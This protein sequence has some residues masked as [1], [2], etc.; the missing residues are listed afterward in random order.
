MLQICFGIYPVLACSHFLRFWGRWWMPNKMIRA[1]IQN[2]KLNRLR[3]PSS[4]AFS[5]VVCALP[6]GM[7]RAGRRREHTQLYT[8]EGYNPLHELHETDGFSS[9]ISWLAADRLPACAC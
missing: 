4:A 2:Q 5:F 1:G 7:L 6:V 3:P 8:F 9:A